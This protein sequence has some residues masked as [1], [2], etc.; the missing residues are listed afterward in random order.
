MST[1]T[2]SSLRTAG[3][4][5]QSYSNC[6]HWEGFITTEAFEVI[7]AYTW[8]L[9]CFKSLE[10]NSAIK[11]S[12]L[13]LFFFLFFLMCDGSNSEL[14][15][16]SCYLLY[17]LPA[18]G[19]DKALHCLSNESRTLSTSNSSICFLLWTYVLHQCKD[20]ETDPKGAEW[21][22]EQFLPL[23]LKMDFFLT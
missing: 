6:C 1:K 17:L 21:E 12:L 20:R 4:L 11:I 9:K 8:T 23:S 13:L 18:P 5:R 7:D 15:C 10:Q 22:G 14:S 19:Q 3:E 2:A 16:G